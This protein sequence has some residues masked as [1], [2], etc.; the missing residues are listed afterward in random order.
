MRKL[1]RTAHLWLGL[2]SGLIMFVV[3]STGALYVFE[4]ELRDAVQSHLL[5]VPAQ[6]ANTRIINASEVCG[7][8]KRQFPR[9]NIEQ[10]RFRSL[11]TEANTNSRAAAVLVFTKNHHVYSLNPY[12]AQILGVRDSKTD[13]INITVEL[14]TALLL[15]RVGW[16]DVGEQ[17]VKWNVLV[18]FVML[19]TG[20]VLW[21]PVNMC[22][23]RDALKKSLRVKW[24]VKPSSISLRRNYDLHRVAGFYAFWVML[25]VAWTGIF[26][27]FDF[28]EDGIYAG[29]GAKKNYDVKPLSSK[30]MTTNS[31]HAGA[32][33][34]RTSQIALL[35]DRTHAEVLRYG[36]PALV[37]LQLP[38]KETD[39]L[40]V[41]VRYPYRF[42]RKQS[43]FYFDQYAGTLLKSDLHE[44]YST[45]DKIRVANF[46][47]HTGRMLGLPSKILWFMAA[48]FT[49][50]LPV[51]GTMM[52]WQKRRRRS[53][54]NDR[55]DR[56]AGGLVNTSASVDV[57]ANSSPN[58]S[59]NPRTLHEKS[60]ANES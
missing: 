38:K 54:R 31:T 4:E 7:V 57:P 47:L 59:P 11:P 49:A 23:L 22:L 26:W 53:N 58:S 52:W 36:T 17:I 40:R 42:V 34:D 1:I 21:M 29:F 20:I 55:N 35:L 32:A 33:P 60:P 28:V 3:A 37:N 16:K 12:T 45:P 43:M 24:R 39:A 25:I 51:T 14:H 41:L 30:P 27:M 9:D 48:I 15:E 18:F 19:I 6:A 10:I 13:L 2:A 50:S 56:N 8:I 44:Q 46:D 5:Y